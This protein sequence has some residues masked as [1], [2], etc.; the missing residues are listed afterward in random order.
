M[1]KSYPDP[2][3]EAQALAL[4]AFEGALAPSKQ[5]EDRLGTLFVEN[6]PLA[7]PK[8][9]TIIVGTDLL[10]NGIPSTFETS[11]PNLVMFFG[12]GM[13]MCTGLFV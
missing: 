7:F 5:V 2:P 11:I 10:V 4:K 6:E 3:D 12:N 13:E 1:S 9:L 8:E